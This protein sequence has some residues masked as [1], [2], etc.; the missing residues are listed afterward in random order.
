M[1]A[2]EKRLA[3]LVSPFLEGKPNPV[4]VGNHVGQVGQVNQA[5]AESRQSERRRTSAHRRR[6]QRGEDRCAA[7]NSS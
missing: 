6:I 5:S 1:N 3:A 7:R 4:T 2:E